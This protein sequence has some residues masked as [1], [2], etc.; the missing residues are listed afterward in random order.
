[1]KRSKTAFLLKVHLCFL[2]LL[3]AGSA[4]SAF[5]GRWDGLA[6]RVG[7]RDSVLVADPSGR[8]LFQKNGEAG[9]LP[10]STLKVFTALMA[11]HFLGTDFRFRTEFFLTPAGDLAVKGYG[12]P[13][14]ISEVVAEMAAEVA[15]RVDGFGDLILD[16]S[17]FGDATIPGV[18]ATL[19][20]YDAP[21]GALAVNFN[22]VQFRKAGNRFVSGEPQ[23]PLLPVVV[24]RLRRSGLNR[25]RVVLSAENGEAPRYAGHL[26]RHFLAA[27]GVKTD[28][29]VRAGGVRPETD[30]LVYRFLSPFS[31]DEV[32]ERLLEFSNNFIANQCFIAAGVAAS[33]PPGT[34]DKGRTAARSFAAE[35]LKIPGVQVDE[36]S[37]ISRE[38]RVAAFQMLKILEAFAPHYRLMKRE[39][40]EWFKTGSL[41]GVKTRAGY[42]AGEGGLYRF[43]VFVNTAGRGTGPVMRA[44]HR[45]VPGPS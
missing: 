35:V 30:R 36:G 2:I 21:N 22:T 33:G 5:A 1:M 4:A 8:V 7:R 13:L 12:D 9:R 10:A 15:R 40:R 45:A 28:G 24:D 38:N 11:R 14:L 34:L 44:I 32:T 31:L 16:A 6:A 3:L 39:G 25:G 29:E 26:I 18:T 23:T 20:P 43:V 17:H 27:A 41:S 19:N 42:L 37:G